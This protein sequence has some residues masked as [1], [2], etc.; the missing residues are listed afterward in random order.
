MIDQGSM[1]A[2]MSEFKAKRMIQSYEVRIAAPAARVFPLLCPMREYDW[3]DGWSCDLVYSDSG[4]AEHNCI[5]QTDRAGQGRRT[6]VVSRYE[7]NRAIDFV[8]FQDDL[9]VIRY[10]LYLSE[11]GDGTSN[12]RITQTITGLNAAGNAAIDALPKDLV[13]QHWTFLEKALNHYLLTGV[14]LSS[15][16]H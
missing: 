9:G 1:E 16:S 14:M 4:V 2:V 8:I 6:W 15:A 13:Q 7:P 12:L 5:F 11:N 10:D 3:I